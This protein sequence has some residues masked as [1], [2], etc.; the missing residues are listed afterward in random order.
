MAS[1]SHRGA[2]AEAKTRIVTTP[3]PGFEV[4]HARGGADS[5]QQPRNSTGKTSRK[6]QRN[7]SARRGVPRKAGRSWASRTSV[8]GGKCR[9]GVSVVARAVSWAGC[10]ARSG[11]LRSSECSCSRSSFGPSRSRRSRRSSRSGAARANVSSRR[12][13]T[14][15]GRPPSRDVRAPPTRVAHALARGGGPR[16][17]AL[18]RP[19]VDGRRKPSEVCGSEALG[20]VREYVELPLVI[21]GPRSPRRHA[22]V[23]RVVYAICIFLG[24][25]GTKSWCRRRRSVGRSVGSKRDG[26]LPFVSRSRARVARRRGIASL[27]RRHVRPVWSAWRPRAAHALRASK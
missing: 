15:C 23:A 12:S 20:G 13:V 7:P 3:I 8:G 6:A 26:S 11:S 18:S 17:G 16:A 4:L 1:T 22:Y 21:S 19:L 14:C 10:R 2:V 27:R 24:V 9:S 25:A 5:Q